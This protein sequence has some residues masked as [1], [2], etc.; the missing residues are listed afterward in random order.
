MS[1]FRLPFFCGLQLVETKEPSGC[2]Y[3]I[4]KIFGGKDVK[5]FIQMAFCSYRMSCKTPNAAPVSLLH[6]HSARAA[7][8]ANAGSTRKSFRLD[9]V[10]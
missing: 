6:A 3:A 5:S 2:P 1:A 4:A 8:P 9:R 7:T 10:S